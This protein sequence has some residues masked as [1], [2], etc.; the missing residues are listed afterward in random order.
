MPQYK[1]ASEQIQMYEYNNKNI[2]YTW[3]VQNLIKVLN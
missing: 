3:L 2:H 1:F